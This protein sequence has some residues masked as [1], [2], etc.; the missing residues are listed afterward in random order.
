MSVHQ[1]GVVKYG[2]TDCINN[3]EHVVRFT[4]NILRITEIYCWYIFA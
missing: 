3:L 2:Q 4:H 1:M